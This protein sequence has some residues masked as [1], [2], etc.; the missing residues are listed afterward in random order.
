MA[1]RLKTNGQ[2]CGGNLL[3]GRDKD[4]GLARAGSLAELVGQLEQP[5][6]LTGHRRDH[7]DQIIA[8]GAKAGDSFRDRL[9]PLD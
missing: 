7:N 8:L 4:V 3:A 9:D 6:G 5:V 2:Q 1:K